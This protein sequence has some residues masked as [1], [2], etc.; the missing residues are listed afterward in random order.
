MQKRQKMH[1]LLCL[2]LAILSLSR[3]SWAQDSC[4]SVAQIISAQGEIRVNKV[5]IDNATASRDR[6]TVCTGDIISAGQLSRAAIAILNT[7]TV[8]RIDQ[9][10][11]LRLTS[12]PDKDPSFLKLFKGAINILSPA[13]QAL[14]VDA[15]FV[16]AAVE[17]T[18]FHIRVEGDR[19]IVTVLQGQVRASNS[20]GSPVSLTSGQS[21]IARKGQAPKRDSSIIPKD[22]IQWALYYP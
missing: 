7:E 5:L 13:P 1:W 4:E 8:I 10:S 12:P 9:N 14:E 3:L 19:A 21:A 22:T 20:S 2:S 16:N 11:E 17:G 6:L 15:R 18:E